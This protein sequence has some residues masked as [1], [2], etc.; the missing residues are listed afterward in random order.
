MIYSY[1]APY[2]KI[3]DIAFVAQPTTLGLNHQNL[4]SVAAIV[5]IN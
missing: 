2:D 5:L 4:K 3:L 1:H